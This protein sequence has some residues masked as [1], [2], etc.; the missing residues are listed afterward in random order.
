M[1]LVNPR[2]QIML[3]RISTSRTELVDLIKAWVAISLA[4]A[5]L[6]GG[7][8]FSFDFIGFFM[9]SSLSVGLGFIA[10]EMSHKLVAQK[11]GCQAEFRAW[12]KM[13]ILAVLMSFFGFIIAAPGAVMI[14]G[15]VGRRRNG[16][17]SAAGAI[18]NLSIAAICLSLALIPVTGIL[19]M[20]AKYGFLINT[21]L[22]L[23]NMIPFAMFDGKKVYNWNKTVYFIMVAVAISFLALQGVIFG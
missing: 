2:D 22:A 9:I 11:Y 6:L 13:L 20:I 1:K 12:D 21:W 4:F 15:P 7:S 8:L 18:A 17:I 23:F 16:K 10:H 5:I 14:A 19:L 3:G